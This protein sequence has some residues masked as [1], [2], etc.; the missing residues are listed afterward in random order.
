MERDHQ[1]LGQNG[2]ARRAAVYN[3][4]V[5]AICGYT[6]LSGATLAKL[7]FIF[8][9]GLII[10]GLICGYS[11]RMPKGEADPQVKSDEDMVRCSHCGVHLPRSESILAEGK[12]FCSEEHRRIK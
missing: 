2:T 11:R 7:I 10:Y 6:S 9:V 4:A 12:F 5:A 3:R 8:I 1:I